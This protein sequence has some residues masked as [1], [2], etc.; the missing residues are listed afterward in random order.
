MPA[1]ARGPIPLSIYGSPWREDH[2][3]G[4]TV[5]PV[6]GSTPGTQTF[7]PSW[8]SR[9]TRDSESRSVRANRTE[10][11]NTEGTKA[12]I[13]GWY[14]GSIRALGARDAGSIPAPAT[15]FRVSVVQQLA[16]QVLSLKTRVRFPTE[17]P[18]EPGNDSPPGAQ[19]RASILR[20]SK[21]LG[22]AKLQPL[23]HWKTTVHTN[24]V[25]MAPTFREFT[26][27][28]ILASESHDP[29]DR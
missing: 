12:F 6:P 10:G 27:V 5:A 8:C 7:I 14:R 16:R 17:I 13:A 3:Y 24:R 9:S 4:D 1:K 15:I 18:T 29:F 20:P 11:T 23:D 19:I 26:R 21:P 25:C 2:A 22:D 28:Q